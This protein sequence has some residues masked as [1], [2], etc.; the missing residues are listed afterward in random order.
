MMSSKWLSWPMLPLCL[1]AAIVVV[2][3]TNAVPDPASPLADAAPDCTYPIVDTGQDR[4]FSNAREI[5]YPQSGKPFCGQDAQYQGRTPAY[6]GHGDGTVSDLST[7][8]MWVQTPSR[9]TFAEAV[10]GAARCR[11]GGYSDWR[12]PTIKELYSLIDFRGYSARTVAQSVPY[13]DTKY[14]DFTYGERRLIDAQY[15]SSTEYVGT[16]MNGAATV[17]GVNFADGRIKGYPRDIGPFGTPMQQFVRYVRGNPGYGINEFVDNGDGTITDQATERTWAQTDSGKAMT[18]QEALLYAEHLELA[19]HDDWRLPNAKELQS[20]VDYSRAP[21]AAH[22]HQVGPAIDPVFQLSQNGSWHWTGTTHLENHSCGFAVYLCFGR[23]F[24]AMHGVRMNVHGA[25]AQRS[26]PKTGDPEVW[27]SGNG[28][29]GDEVRINN[30]VRC[31]RGGGVTKRTRGPALD[32][33]YTAGRQSPHRGGPEHPDQRGPGQGGQ[34]GPGQRPEFVSRLDQDGDGKVSR[35]EF[36]GP[37]DHFGVLDR[38][39]DGYLSETEAPKG[40][41]PGSRPP[42][43]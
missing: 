3:S 16:T 20:I 29:Q 37:R 39:G 17:F 36:D 26:D 9:K 27:S 41:P 6:T 35:T 34:R 12:L 32:G 18:W 42:R 7:G 11:E 30:Y 33:S 28:P 21:D 4:C 2:S 1:G 13:I 25:G 10:A 14:F 24:G 8:L 38:N 23:A 43:R 5:V 19:G 31:V 15:W 22:P 40:P